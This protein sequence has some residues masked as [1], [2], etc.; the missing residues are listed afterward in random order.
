GVWSSV[1]GLACV[2]VSAAD[3]GGATFPLRWRWCNPLP[4]GGIV[5]DMAYCSALR[6]G[7]QVAERGQVYTSDDLSLWLPRDSGTTNSLRAVTFFGTRIIV[8]G[9]NGCVLYADDVDQFRSGRLWDGPTE[10]WL[11]AVAAS[12]SLVVA[13]GD[14]GAI[15]TSVDGV[16]WHRQPNANEHW[17]RG[18]AYG[19]GMW[20]A[21]GRVGTV[22]WSADGT[23]WAARVLGVTNHLNRVRYAA[24]RF[25]AV[26]DQ[27]ICLASTNLGATWSAE[28]TGASRALENA[29]A[30]GLDQIAV[31]Y[32]EVRLKDGLV[33][34][35]ELGKT[36]GP[37]AWTYYGAIGL[38]GYF[39]IAGQSGMQS[40]AYQT[41]S[42]PY[43][44]L[45]P[46]DSVRH[47]LW[48]VVYA[49]FLYVA[50]GD[51]GTVMTSGNGVSWTLELVPP[52]VTNSTFLGVG[53]TTNLLIAV[54]D[55]GS[56]IVSPSVVSN[57]VVTNVSGVVTQTVNSLGVVWHA[58]WP[59]PT[60]FDLQGVAV[61]TNGLYVVTG[62]SGTVL[63]STNG[64]AW[65]SQSTPA[66]CLLSSVTEWPG[67]LVAT[68]D[69]GTLL[70]S[71]D[72]AHWTLLPR[73]TTNW[74]YRVRY[75]NGTLVAVG[76]Q[77]VI[78]TS[79]DGVAWTARD[80]G[81][82]RWLN[83]VVFLDGT[84]FAVGTL[85]TVLASTDLDQWTFQG[86]LTKQKALYGAATDGRQLV[87]V[88]VEGA[89]LRS[90]VVPDLTPIEI[91][92]FSRIAGTNANPNLNL[93][94]FGGKTDQRFTLDRCIGLQTPAWS[95][96][97]ALEIF[98]PAGVLYYVERIAG[99][100]QPAQE[101]YR[102]TLQP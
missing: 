16:E 28:M 36:N 97:K 45:T 74:L 56:M 82:R 42:A 38:P 80:S 69:D 18:V 85:G 13:V 92:A 22:L 24:D 53:G 87:T 41:N 49:S 75:L 54:G 29:C 51:F 4:H 98:D 12:P 20:I 102:A 91:L 89:I 60:T 52:S 71:P 61:L 78:L 47:W 30:G 81:T 7:V 34:G 93:F 43:F 88:G 8:T 48:D 100:N 25:M 27:G 33:W 19:G 57:V 99:T 1:L 68:G 73:V 76:E 77:G 94:L 59:R 70:T 31:G 40:E 62:G 32:D 21:V 3:A 35:D 9:E 11:E 15:Y 66:A 84:Y 86:T 37:P 63:T 39:L 96:G 55:A 79:T 14:F 17:L 95:A 101:Y 50:V 64:L 72:G 44:W 23:N 67:G 26:G 58:V 2:L 6:R 46:Y 83:D 5:V 90:S 10:D 65:T